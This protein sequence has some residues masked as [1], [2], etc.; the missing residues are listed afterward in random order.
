MGNWDVVG[1][2]LV[3][4]VSKTSVAQD[5]ALIS[6]TYGTDYEITADAQL[7]SGDGYGIYYRTSETPTSTDANAIS[8][9]VFQ[10]DHGLGDKFVIRKV[11][12][13]AE[14]GTVASASM[15]SGF[16]VNGAHQIT[17]SVSGNTTIVKVDGTQVLSY[18]DSSSTFTAGLVGVR[19]WSNSDA[20][21]QD[22]KVVAK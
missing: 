3:S 4:R 20:T 19:S 11:T 9:Y 18:T 1:N 22:L 15:P 16:A 7:S 5:R 2:S 12:N 14:S 10:F 21:V 17:L 6:G 8:G 13:G